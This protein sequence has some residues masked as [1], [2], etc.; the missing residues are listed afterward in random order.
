MWILSAISSASMPV[1]CR[2]TRSRGRLWE[3][4]LERLGVFP[5]VRLLKLIIHLAF[6][7]MLHMHLMWSWAQYHLQM[8]KHTKTRRLQAMTDM[9]LL[10]IRPKTRTRT[11]MSL[12]LIRPKTR[13]RTV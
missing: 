13:T 6:S 7:K 1:S 3:P 4:L 10:L 2:F 9:S 5:S 8:C 11:D 12:L